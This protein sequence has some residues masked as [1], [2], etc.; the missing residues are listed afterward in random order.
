MRDGAKAAVIA[1][2]TT[3]QTLLGIERDLWAN[4]D[5]RRYGSLDQRS[6]NSSPG[7]VTSLLPGNLPGLNSPIAAIPARIAGDRIALSEF[8]AGQRNLESLLPFVPIVPATTR[9]SVVA[10]GEVELRPDLVASA[11]VMYV[12]RSVRSPTL[13]PLFPVVPVPLTNPFNPFHV[14]VFVNSLLEGME[15]QEQNLESTLTRGVGSLHGKALAWNWEFSL[16]RS[17]EDAELSLENTLDI[18]RLMQVLANPD[19]S[20][21]LDLFRP[22]PAA[23]QEILD[24]L[25]LPPQVSTYATDASQV[26]GLANGRVLEL[27]G[28]LVTA[29]V[30]GEWRKESVQFDSALGSSEREVGAGF[31]ELTIPLFSADMHVPALRELKLTAGGR[32]D[33]YSDFGQILNPQF[34]L[35]W[36][37]YQELSLHASYSRSFRA[38]SM[39]ELHLPRQVSLPLFP[40]VDPLRGGA[41][42]AVA[43]ITGGNPELEPTRGESFTAGFVF[44]P[45]VLA[46][47]ELFATYWHVS[48]DNRITF[49]QPRL[50][51]TNETLFPER[52]I[53]AEPTPA[54]L[55][56]GRP[57]NI[58]QIDVS[59]MNFGRLATSGIDLGVRYE[60]ESRFG[61]FAGNAVATWIGEF[62]TVDVP[63]TP[64]A[65]R[66]NIANETVGTITKWRA[67]AGLDWDRRCAQCDDARALHS[68]LRRHARRRPQRP[69]HRGADLPRPANRNRSRKTGC[70]QPAAARRRAGGRCVE[71][72]GRAAGLC[73]SHRHPGIRHLPRRPQRALLVRAAR[74]DFLSRGRSRCRRRPSESID[75]LRAHDVDV[76]MLVPIEEP[77]CH[78][79]ARILVE[80]HGVAE[81]VRVAEVH[82]HGW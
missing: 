80:R 31:A 75:E 67:V 22:G 74:Q 18:L 78:D 46:P 21:T 44:T 45:Q 1:D 50:V 60:I 29:M 6:I 5:Y 72:A 3:T 33:H 51:L 47:V 48:M 49:L 9:A 70:R 25:V 41:A 81:Q 36:L 12:D 58:L 79:V 4:Q 13:P 71:S 76:G 39:F 16:L 40:V 42:T 82:Q 27:P 17:E 53:R 2:Y 26:S 28:G 54:D 38:P 43:L 62:E 11:E 57:G 64:A 63:A 20:Q 30:G 19:P 73:G 10:N 66:I 15:R 55:A 35:Q 52:V 65:N 68:V 56:A 34:G 37:P 14:P 69:S 8:L 61:Q 7:N 77:G 23:S 24:S 32:L 59:R